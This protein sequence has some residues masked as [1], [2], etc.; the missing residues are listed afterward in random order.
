MPPFGKQEIR[1]EIRDHM[2]AIQMYQQA[3]GSMVN[4]QRQTAY[5]HVC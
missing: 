4:V 5:L 1:G 3:L 2:E